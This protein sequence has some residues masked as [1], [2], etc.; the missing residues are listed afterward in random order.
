MA[1]WGVHGL[2][3]HRFYNLICLFYGANPADR[4]FFAN[5]LGLPEERADSCPEEYDQAIVSLGGGVGSDGR[6]EGKNN[7]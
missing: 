4:I 5:D 7:I 1:F 6:P 2:D 3:E